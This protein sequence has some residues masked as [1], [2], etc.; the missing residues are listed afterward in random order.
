MYL[1]S[2]LFIYLIMCRVYLS[3]PTVSD[4][5]GFYEISLH[6]CYWWNISVTNGKL[7][8]A[9]CH[10]PFLLVMGEETSPFSYFIHVEVEGK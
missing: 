5:I 6:M 9:P 7:H 1:L 2:D 3:L 4:Q 8:V 10:G